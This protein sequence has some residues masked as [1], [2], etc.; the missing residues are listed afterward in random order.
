MQQPRAVEIT[1]AGAAVMDEGLVA[2]RG[3]EPG[4][5]SQ[6]LAEPFLLAVEREGA[7]PVATFAQHEHPVGEPAAQQVGGLGV[8]SELLLLGEGRKR[9]IAVAAGQQHGAAVAEGRA[10]PGAIPELAADGLLLAIEPQRRVELAAGLSDQALA[11]ERYRQPVVE[12][13]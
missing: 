13:V 3:G 9:C 1:G 11:A 8:A 7:L 10:Q 5:V 6:L 12:G 2:Q 4:T